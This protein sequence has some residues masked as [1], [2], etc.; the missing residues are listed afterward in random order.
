MLNEHAARKKMDATVLDSFTALADNNEELRIEAGVR[1]L[2]HV[3]GKQIKF[4][5]REYSPNREHV[6]CVSRCEVS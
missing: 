1:L 4:H 5:V 2:E 6:I 3:F